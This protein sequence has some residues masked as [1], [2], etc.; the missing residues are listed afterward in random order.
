MVPMS[1]S[2]CLHLMMKLAF[3][4]TF[5]R[6]RM[7][8]DIPLIEDYSWKLSRRQREL[9]Q[10]LYEQPACKFCGL[11][12]EVA[13]IFDERKKKHVPL[14]RGEL[15]RGLLGLRVAAWDSHL[16]QWTPFDIDHIVPRVHGGS[17]ER[18]NKQVTCVA[19]NS[20]KSSWDRPPVDWL[21]YRKM[22][23]AEEFEGSFA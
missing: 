13:A 5:S 7:T 9:L 6:F 15:K 2:V 18:H 1:D 4:P 16:H 11:Y 20:R 21:H 19:C 17:N 12:A 10:F 23:L 8:S 3:V 14:S 22:M